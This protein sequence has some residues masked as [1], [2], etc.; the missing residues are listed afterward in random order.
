MTGNHFTLERGFTTPAPQE[1]EVKRTILHS[2]KKSYVLMDSSKYG[3][4]SLCLIAPVEDC[5]TMI[6]DWHI[7]DTLRSSFAEKGVRL[8][9]AP[10]IV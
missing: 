2:G 4:N 5:D 8:I 1:A 6:T 7:N 3:D 10:E 9:I